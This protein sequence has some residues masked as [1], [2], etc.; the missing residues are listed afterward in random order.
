M[1]TTAEAASDG[2]TTTTAAD[3]PAE[4]EHGLSRL[5]EEE[6][7]HL[8]ALIRDALNEAE[9][10]TNQVNNDSM[11]RYRDYSGSNGTD[12]LDRDHAVSRLTEARDCAQVAVDYLYKVTDA[13][14]DQDEPF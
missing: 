7:Y 12:P 4:R 2:S 1:T 11:D 3:A 6:C 10:L 8:T 13:L 14:R 5:R 9:R